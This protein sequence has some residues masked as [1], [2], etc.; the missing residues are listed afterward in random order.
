MTGHITLLN[1]TIANNR[2]G[3][4]GGAILGSVSLTGSTISGNIAAYSGGISTDPTA[5]VQATDSTIS[6]NR[7][8]GNGSVIDISD[9][10]D[11]SWFM[12]VTIT[13]NTGGIHKG[14]L[15]FIDHYVILVDMILANEGANCEGGVLSGDYNIVSD[16]S[17][18][19]TQPHDQQGM[20]PL[21]GPLA[22]N[23]GPTPTH[24]LLP[25]SPAIDAGSCVAGVTTDQRGIARP[26]GAT[27]DIGAY[28]YQYVA[29]SPAG[30]T[31]SSTAVNPAPAPI[32]RSGGSA[33]AS[34]QGV[35]PTPNPLPSH[36]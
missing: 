5:S 25:G 21:L 13:N 29:P 1:S 22:S 31:G 8:S 35:L 27:C 32:P 4:R 6:S 11:D 3:G 24:A 20:N 2:S 18:G 30:R 9:P 16:T 23:G 28:E 33:S 14:T 34:G 7:D 36:R 15:G 10:I 17:C 12:N 19:F 26:Q